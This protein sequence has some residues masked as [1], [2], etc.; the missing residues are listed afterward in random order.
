MDKVDDDAKT[1][2]Y[3]KMRLWELPDQYIVEPTD[4]GTPDSFLAISRVD[5]SLNLIGGLIDGA[6]CVL[7]V[8]WFW[9]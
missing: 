1:K 5:G 4:G 3:T 2:L 6:S 9:Y 7:F 8:V